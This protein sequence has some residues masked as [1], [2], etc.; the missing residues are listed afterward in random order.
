MKG[1]TLKM[2]LNGN[3][4]GLI[5]DRTPA[6]IQGVYLWLSKKEDLA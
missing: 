4:E 5:T 1:M 2:L 6:I 3:S